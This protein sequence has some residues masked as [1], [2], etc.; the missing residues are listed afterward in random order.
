MLQRQNRPRGNTKFGLAGWLP[1]PWIICAD[2][3]L[4]GSF[5]EVLED[6]LEWHFSPFHLQGVLLVGWNKRRKVRT[7]HQ[8][9]AVLLQCGVLTPVVPHLVKYGARQKV[10]Y[11]VDVGAAYLGFRNRFKS[12]RQR[13][14][15][16][17]PFL[18]DQVSN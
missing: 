4:A 2:D 5:F 17:S 11:G 1:N 18:W 3:A 12:I 8:F 14:I 9:K 15:L 13:D 10:D 16:I 6:C 7:S